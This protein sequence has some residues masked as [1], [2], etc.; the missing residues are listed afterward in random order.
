ME[1]YTLNG[2]S[3]EHLQDRV[4][5]ALAFISHGDGIAYYKAF[6]QNSHPLVLE[7]GFDGFE[8]FRYCFTS[9]KEMSS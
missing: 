8:H 5:I 9:P 3:S 1:K 4:Q 2:R 6:E 7:N